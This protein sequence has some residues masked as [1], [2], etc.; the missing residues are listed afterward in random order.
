MAIAYFLYLAT[1]GSIALESIDPKIPWGF[2]LAVCSI[3]YTL[4]IVA[5]AVAWHVLL[6]SC[7]ER[8]GVATSISIC[9]ISQAAKYIPGN[10]AHHIGRVYLAKR[11]GIGTRKTLYTMLIETLFLVGVGA[12]FSVFAISSIGAYAG[13]D[14][15][16]FSSN[17]SF[18]LLSLSALGLPFVL[19]S[20]AKKIL[21]LWPDFFGIGPKAIQPTSALT[22]IKLV[23]IYA[24]GFLLLGMVLYF[25]GASIVDDIDVSFLVLTGIFSFSWTVGFLTPGAPAGIGIRELLLTAGLSQY[26]GQELAVNLAIYLRVISVFGDTAALLLGLSLAGITKLTKK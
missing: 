17:L 15:G 14:V 10:V 9:C 25:A 2:M 26:V 24:L 7:G 3:L 8:V 20:L 21:I 4:S 22:G 18:V 12:S 1:S 16:L 13:I 5:G 11:S 6:A 23:V 19:P